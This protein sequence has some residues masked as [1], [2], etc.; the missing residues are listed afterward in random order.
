MILTY[1]DKPLKIMKNR[2]TDGK[3]ID[4]I[5]MDHNIVNKEWLKYVTRGWGRRFKPP[6]RQ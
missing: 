2:F 1:A 3:A 5:Y 6:Y 4:S